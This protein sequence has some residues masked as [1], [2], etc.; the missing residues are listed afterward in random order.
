MRCRGD[1]RELPLSPI[2]PAPVA[3][4]APSTAILSA[5]PVSILYSIRTRLA[6]SAFN[7][8]GSEAA[9]PPPLFSPSADSKM[10]IGRSDPEVGTASESE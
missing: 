8:E 5:S 9:P 3:V 2:D 6:V 4:A 1:S 10:A 7:D